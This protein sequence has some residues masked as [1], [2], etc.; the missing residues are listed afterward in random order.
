MSVDRL[1][2]EVN[3]K[4]EVF[5]QDMQEVTAAALGLDIRAGYHLF[6]SEECIAVKKKDDR[7]LQYYGGFEYVDSE[8]RKEIG[9]YVFYICDYGE[10]CRVNACI[11]TWRENNE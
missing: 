7:R 1:I 5:L 11:E 3:E 9:D 2:K 6:V 10:D 8:F 4:I